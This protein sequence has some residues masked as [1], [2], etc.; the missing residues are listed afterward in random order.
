MKSKLIELQVKLKYPDTSIEDKKLL[1]KE[2]RKI[3]W[4]LHKNKKTNKK[5]LINR[6]K[7]LTKSQIFHNNYYREAPRA[8][9]SYLYGV[10][11]VDNTGLKKV[12]PLAGERTKNY[13]KVVRRMGIPLTSVSHIYRTDV[14]SWGDHTIIVY[15]EPKNKLLKYKKSNPSRIDLT[16][17][18]CLKDNTSGNVLK[19]RKGTFNEELYTYISKQEYKSTLPRKV[20]KQA[21]KAIKINLGRT[22][23]S[24][25]WEP[26]YPELTT[27]TFREKGIEYE[28]EIYKR[29]TG[30][31]R[32]RRRKLKTQDRYIKIFEDISRE[33][34]Y[35]KYTNPEW[36]R[37]TCPDAPNLGRKSTKL[38]TLAEKAKKRRHL[39]VLKSHIK[40]RKRKR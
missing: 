12:I 39:N 2:I 7:V 20:F 22:G 29:N 21:K 35:D 32:E 25:N 8:N 3:E 38:I 5:T 14:K 37:Y 31:I 18:V 6:E 11:Y 24:A 17:L 15:K 10:H 1:C 9:Q 16:K 33:V 36:Q 34:D 4:E 23:M 19:L 13:Q 40:I 27:I 30:I 28:A 26:I